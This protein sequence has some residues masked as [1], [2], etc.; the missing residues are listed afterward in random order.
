MFT[1]SDTTTTAEVGTTPVPGN[2]PTGWEAYGTSCY[3]FKPDVQYVSMH[4][5]IA[6]YKSNYSQLYSFFQKW[7]AI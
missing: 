4:Y 2:C 1:V 5:C 3:L 6:L 7:F